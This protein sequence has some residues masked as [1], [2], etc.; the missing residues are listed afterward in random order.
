MMILS[1]YSC[2]ATGMTLLSLFL[3][4]RSDIRRMSFLCKYYRKLP[5]R[6]QVHDAEILLRLLYYFPSLLPGDPLPSR[7][8]SFLIFAFIIFHLLYSVNCFGIIFYCILD[9]SCDFLL[10]CR[11]FRT[12]MTFQ[13]SG[14]SVRLRCSKCKR[15]V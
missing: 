6:N 7:L 4:Y 5:P 14:T 9:T 13:P 12:R 15:C 3:A 1:L 8:L 10:I 2:L 11:Y